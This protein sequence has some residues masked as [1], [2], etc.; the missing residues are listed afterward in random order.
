MAD[1]N[2]V[3]QEGGPGGIGAAVPPN[4]APNEAPGGTPGGT[5]VQPGPPNN[6]QQQLPAQGIPYQSTFYTGHL[7][8]PTGEVGQFIN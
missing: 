8:A 5:P 1:A 6:G 4:E 2:A 3:T 7:P